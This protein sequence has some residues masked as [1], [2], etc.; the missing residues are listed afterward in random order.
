MDCRGLR[1]LQEVTGGFRALGGGLHGVTGGTFGCSGLQG[2]AGGN[3]AFRRLQGVLG[4][5]KGSQGVT[6]ASS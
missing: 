2:I 4:H 1:G 6:E 5:Y 3:R